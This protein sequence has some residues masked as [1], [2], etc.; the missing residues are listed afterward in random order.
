MSP[1]PTPPPIAHSNGSPSLQLNAIQQTEPPTILLVEDDPVNRMVLQ[2]LLEQQGYS[3]STASDGAQAFDAAVTGD[4]AAIVM[5][6]RLPI[7]D[8]ITVTRMIRD[9]ERDREQVR[10][11]IIALTG[12]TRKDSLRR[13]ADASANTVLLKPVTA[14]LLSAVLS[15]CI[16]EQA[17]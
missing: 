16:G 8:G 9:H 3:V 6:C 1:S 7:F 11:P 10:V 2:E 13:C 4:Y 15:Q 14:E 17:E 12:E 5:D